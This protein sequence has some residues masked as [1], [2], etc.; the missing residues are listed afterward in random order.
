MEKQAASLQ[1]QW[2]FDWQRNNFLALPDS[3]NFQRETRHSEVT[4]MQSTI[5]SQFLKNEL[6]EQ[7]TPPVYNFIVLEQ[8]I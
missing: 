2:L 4:A 1:L 5:S 8:L 6:V 3:S 7:Q